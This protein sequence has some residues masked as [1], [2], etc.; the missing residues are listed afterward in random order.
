ML[1]ILYKNNLAKNKYMRYLTFCFVLAAQVAISQVSGNRNYSN[2]SFLHNSSA[3]ILQGSIEPID[4]AWPTNANLYVDVKG[5]ANV[6]ADAYV[7]IFSVNQVGKTA[8]EVNMLIDTRIS[9]ALESFKGKTGIESFVDMISLVPVYE[10][11]SDK[12]IFS[13][14]TYNEVPAGFEVKKNIHVKYTDHAQLNE[15]LQSFSKQEIYDLVKVDYYSSKIDAVKKEL[16]S[17]CKASINEKL[18]S[19][20]GVV[21]I[22][23]DTLDRQMFEDVKVIVPSQAYKSY[24]A[25]QCTSLNLERSANVNQVNKTTTFY[26]EPV[27]EKEFDIVMN[28]VVLEPVIQVMYNVKVVVDR[29]RARNQKGEKGLMILTPNGELKNVNLGR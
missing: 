14:K 1:L 13:K 16:A 18:K 20:Y 9:A 28:P 10:Y 25:Y 3:Q 4:V 23:S 15:M 8:E 22:K 2:Q 11:Q 26:Y 19:M 5:L 29:E 12:K 24:Q 21:A 17:K 27:S 6:K 7:A